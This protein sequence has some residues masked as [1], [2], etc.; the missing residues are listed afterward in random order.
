[1]QINGKPVLVG[2][3]PEIF[4]G[5]KGAFVSAHGL[6]A[7]DKRHP[8]PVEK[9]AVQVDGLA[10]EFNIDPAS[11]LK[12][13]E[14]NLDIVQAQLRGMIGDLEF[15]Q[16]S[17]VFFE[18]EFLADIPLENLILGCEPDFNAYTRLPNPRPDAATNMRTAGGHIHVG[19]FEAEHPDSP[20]HQGLSAYLTRLM[21]EF[22]GVYSILWD[23]DD[24]RRSMYG[25][26][27]CYRPKSYGFEYRTLSNAWLFKPKL[28][29]F[30]Y[31]GVEDVVD[32]FLNR[33]RNAVDATLFQ[34][35]INNSERDH[36]FFTRN[37]RAEEIRDIVGA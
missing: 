10:L 34:Q 26:A 9:G 4:V 18:K 13:F 30:I 19:G 7:G 1:M 11:S 3:D 17:S 8:L 20:V 12:E 28:A 25:Q 14:T 15:L 29:A 32:A 23:K 27:G 6:V 24:H 5:R 16:N 36:T 33:D 2:A 21:D 35:I 22:V 37:I 31:R